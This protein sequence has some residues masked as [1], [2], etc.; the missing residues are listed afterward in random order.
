MRRHAK[1]SSA[2]STMRRARGFGRL[3]VLA[4]ALAALLLLALAPTLA[5]AAVDPEYL[6][7][8]GPDGTEATSFERIDRVAV[9]EGTGVI[10]VGDWQKTGPL[11]VRLRRPPARLG[12]LRPQHLGERNHRTAPFRS[13]NATK[14]RSIPKPT[15]STSPAATRCRAFE[16]NGE[17]HEFT[18]GPGA[19]TS[20]IPGATELGGVAVDVKGNIYACR[21]SNSPRPI[22]RS[23]ST[24][25]QGRIL[26]E[27]EP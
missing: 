12:R 3:R 22:Q 6:G 24:R 18:A 26:T 23:A 8:F 7:A 11:Q 10:Y 25:A 19:G 20:E 1:A 13:D 21:Q 27:F 17:P 2:G 14:S 9:D 15:S 4:A 16:A 5:A